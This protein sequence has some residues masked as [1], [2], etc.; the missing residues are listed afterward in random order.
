M[1]YLIL[2]V[3]LNSLIPGMSF[4]QSLDPLDS[5]VTGSKY[6]ITLFSEKDITGEIVSQNEKTLTVKSENILMTIDRDNILRITKDISPSKFKFIA[7]LNAGIVS[8][9]NYYEYSSDHKSSFVINGRFSYFYS[10]KRN[11]GVDLSY[12]M[13]N[14]NGSDYGYE[15]HYGYEGVK[16]TNTDILLNWQAGTFDKNNLADIYLNLGAG[17]HIYHRSSYTYTYSYAYNYDTTHY[18]QSYGS[19]TNL[20]PMIQIGG[21]LIIKPFNNLG[22]NLEIDMQFYDFLFIIPGAVSFPIK[23]GI[24]YYFFK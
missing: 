23:A 24:S 4:S 12:S 22:I 14:D 7:T 1:N 2:I 21:G 10:D 15:Y 13:L 19:L 3:L 17:V 20:Y 8:G 6:K 16:Q 5:L 9:S 11:V 18:S